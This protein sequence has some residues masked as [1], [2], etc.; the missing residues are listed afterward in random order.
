MTKI[1]V[2]EFHG[3]AYALVKDDDSD[4]DYLI[5]TPMFADNTFSLLDDDWVEVDELALLGEE[6]V[7]QEHINF[8]HS[9]LSK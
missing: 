9:I 8:V 1:Y 2:S 6:A 5:Q 7:H 3:C 4:G